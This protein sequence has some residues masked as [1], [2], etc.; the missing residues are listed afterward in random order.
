MCERSGRGQVSLSLVEAVV[1][2]LVV[3]AA[4]S[5]FLVGLPET[6]AAERD[7]TVLAA[8]GLSVL[9]ATPAT[10]NASRLAA[11]GRSERSYARQS[12]ATTAQLQELYPDGV[13]F[14]LETPHGALGRP[15][16]TT[17][18]VGRAVA[19]TPGGRVTLRVWIR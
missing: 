11:L 15:L 9:D 17:G 19:W 6:G 7:L 2:L 18:P 13:R 5:T 10:D 12:D 14:R 8:D 3:F 16:S 1:G 4:A